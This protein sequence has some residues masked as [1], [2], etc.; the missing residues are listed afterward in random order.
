MSNYL[1]CIVCKNCALGLF[2]WN[3]NTCSNRYSIDSDGD[4]ILTSYSIPRDKIDDYVTNR[5][6]NLSCNRCNTLIGRKLHNNTLVHTNAV[7]GVVIRNPYSSL[8]AT[9]L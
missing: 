7:D 5:Q 9:D 3:E 4:R 2:L 1:V 8:R 6:N